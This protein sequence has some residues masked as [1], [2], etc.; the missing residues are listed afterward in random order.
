MCKYLMMQYHYRQTFKYPRYFLPID[1]ARKGNP[2][3]GKKKKEVQE[4]KNKP[5]PA[6][7]AILAIVIAFII[8]AAIYYQTN[9][10]N[11][12]AN[13]NQNY[14]SDSGFE[15]SPSG[16]SYLSWSE[17]WEPFMISEDLHHNGEKSALLRLRATEYS[18]NTTVC[19]VV[20]EPTP[21]EMPACISGYYQVR[22]WTRGAS[23]LYIQCVVMALNVSGYDYPVQIRYLIAGASEIPFELGNARFI[24][25]SRD[26]PETGKWSYFN[27]N[28]RQ[29]FM[30]NW[31]F[32]PPDFSKLRIAFE[33]RYDDVPYAIT[34]ADVYW[35]DMYLGD[36]S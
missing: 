3:K 31:G 20:Q 8:M 28:L 23:K 11:P 34:T 21:E 33:V 29:D 17:F 6:V 13:G 36:V 14:F 19:G 22:N 10:I 32:V 9:D 15:S 16:W 30:D 18:Q 27:R 7:K 26:E 25:I 24:F 35:D 4:V 5:F 2:R 1:M 12:P